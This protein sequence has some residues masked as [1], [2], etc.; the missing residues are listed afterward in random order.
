MDTTLRTKKIAGIAQRAI[1]YKRSEISSTLRIE[2]AGDD[3][4][5]DEHFCVIDEDS[6][7]ESMI[8]YEDVPKGAI[9]K[10]CHDEE[11]TF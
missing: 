8:A 4:E 5:F 11:I 1:F 6:G 7:D 3:S 2:Y 9:F 10:V